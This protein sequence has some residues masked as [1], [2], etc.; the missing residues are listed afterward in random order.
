MAFARLRYIAMDRDM[1]N[2]KYPYVVTAWRN[3]GEIHCGD[4][5][6]AGVADILI[7][8]WRADG[9]TVEVTI[10]HITQKEVSA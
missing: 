10:N 7:E 1:D 3:V 5:F 9:I 6:T 2:Y 8:A 4:R